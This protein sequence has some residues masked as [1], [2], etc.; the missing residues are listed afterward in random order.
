MLFSKILSD[1]HY[2]K[3]PSWHIV[4]EW[5]DEISHSL[6]IPIIDSPVSNNSLFKRC[7]SIDNK[8]FNGILYRYVYEIFND[9]SEYSIYFEMYPKS[10]RDFSNRGNV[11]PVILDFWAKSNCEQFRS[12]YGKCPYILITSLEVINY[13]KHNHNMN[14]LVHFPMSLPSFYKLSY[15]K[16][17][18]KRYDMVLAG[19]ANS[20]LWNFLKNYE[21][22]YPGI[23]FLYQIQKEGEIYYV[24]NRGGRAI[25]VHSREEYIS[26]IRS[27]KVAFYAT[28]GMDEGMIRTNGFNPVTPRLFEILSA[29]C[30]VIAR[31]PKNEDTDYFNLETICPSIESYDDFKKQLN[32]ALNSP[33]PIRKNAD[34]LE[35]HYTSNRIG[36]LKEII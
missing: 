9:K 19:R 21:T 14:N 8:L 15:D 24:S 12:L 6:N 22:E 3:W 25:K 32:I 30:H 34:Y 7:K 1:R 28:P 31:Y 29:G 27:A 13:L 23:E 36:I 18:K 26:L 2:Q 33:Q 16:I 11:I 5:E 20:V 17:F 35:Q 10:F 4:Y